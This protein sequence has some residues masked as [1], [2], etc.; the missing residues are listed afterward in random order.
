MAEKKKIKIL[1]HADSP[2]V[3]TGFATVTRNIFQ[4]LGKTGR[5]DITIFGVNDRGGWKDPKEHPYKIY[6][7]MDMHSG[8]VYGRPRFVN[9]VR[10]ADL[11]IRP[12]WDII[13]TLND[14]FIFEQPVPGIGDGLM[15]IMEGLSKAYHDKL[16]PKNWYKTVAYWPVDSWL[17]GNWVQNAVAVADYPVAYTEFGKREIMK[18]DQLLTEPTHVNPRVIYHGF[19]AE[20]FKPI[21]EKEKKEFR[22]KFFQ[23][24]VGEDIFIVSAIAR[25]Q[26][27][28]DLPR[29]LKI[30]REFQ[31]QR[32]HSFLYLHCRETDVHGSLKEYAQFF[33]L[34]HGKDWMTPANFNEN[35]G[36][37]LEVLNKIYN[38]SDAHISATHGEGWG[39]PLVEMMGAKTINIAPNIT[40]I[41][42]IFNTVDSDLSIGSLEGDIRGIP[43]KAGSTTSEWFA[44]GP[45]DYERIRPITNVDDAVEKLLWV[46]DNPDKVQT[47]VDRAYEWV[48]QYS[49]ENM[50]QK[51][52]QLFQE[53][54]KDL[55]KERADAVRKAAA[56]KAKD[57]SAKPKRDDSRS[58]SKTEKEH[59]KN[60]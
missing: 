11:E 45:D 27:R 35:I 49:W 13:F 42:E 59:P 14:P 29:V 51:W 20:H 17:K 4:Y 40:A 36:Y 12:S 56:E 15:R 33:G 2:T 6:P 52:D 57:K 47:I 1:V 50:A 31:K 54:Y 60:G 53:V 3:A 32:P 21:S 34:E 28:K 5:Y 24:Q 37:P 18:A 26:P 58:V 46:Y 39:L 55:E 9:V 44:R 25:N 16:P 48:Q 23:G 8:D 30:F 38:I 22:Q 43:V 41:P 19:D 7:A 10:G